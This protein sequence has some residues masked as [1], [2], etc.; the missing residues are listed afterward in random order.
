MDVYEQHITMYDAYEQRN[1]LDGT[2]ACI[3]YMTTAITCN[4]TNKIANHVQIRNQEPK[5]GI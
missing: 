3:Q 4:P 2:Y 5:H 1:K